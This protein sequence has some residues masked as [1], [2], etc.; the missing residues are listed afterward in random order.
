MQANSIKLRKAGR[1]QQR[2]NRD[3]PYN[4][5]DPVLDKVAVLRQKFGYVYHNGAFRTFNYPESKVLK[6]MT[7]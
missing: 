7:E 6:G 3:R 1:Q 5:G 2:D 4:K